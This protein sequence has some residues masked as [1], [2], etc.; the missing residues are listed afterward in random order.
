MRNPAKWSLPA[1]FGL[2]S[3]LIAGVGILGISYITYQD[4]AGL[5]RMHS[6]QRLGNDL[7]RLSMGLQQTVD[8]LRLDVQQIAD[9]DIIF[10]YNRA[11]SAGG[12]DSQTNMTDA[13]WKQRIQRNFITLLQQRP[14]YI[15]VRYISAQNKGKE[16]VR[17]ERSEGR[18]Q[19]TPENK[20]QQK[21]QYDY[22]RK[23]LKLAM[24][25]QYLSAVNLNREFGRIV[26][27]PQPVLRAAAPVYFHNQVFGVIVVNID[28][29]QI[30]TPFYHPPDNIQY[31]IADKKGDYLYHPDIT[32]R[33]TL[34]LGGRAGVG[35][36]FPQLA[37]PQY[38]DSNKGYSTIDLP[39]KNASM[40]I[41]FLRYDPQNSEHLLLIMAVASH[42]LL[43][44]QVR[45]FRQ[46]LITGVV[47][48]VI[49][50]SFIIS[51]MTY[52]LLQPIEALTHAA[53]LISHGQSNVTLPRTHRD[54]ALGKLA[55][56]FRTMLNH[57]QRSQDELRQLNTELEKKVETRTAELKDA[58]LAANRSAQVKSEFLAS[59]SHEIRTPMNGILGMLNLLLDTRL[60]E[61][62]LHYVNI[63]QGSAQ[64]LLTI[65]NDILDFSKIEAGK[66][67][68]EMM[69]F[70]L[71]NLLSDF[72]ETMALQAQK[73]NLELIL[74]IDPLNYP[75]IN[76]DPGRIRQILTNLTGN[77][78]KFTEQGE[79]I[80]HAR[81][82][83]LRDNLYLLHI[84]VQ[85]SGIGI[86]PEQQQ[87][88]FQS[89]SQGDA[90]TTRKYGGTGLGLAISK[91]LC[92]LMNGGIS[93][94][95]E[96]GKGSVFECTIQ[97]RATE[98]NAHN[99]YYMNLSR[100]YILIVD[101]NR[102]ARKALARILSAWG[103]TIIEA[104]NAPQ[105]LTQCQQRLQTGHRIFELAFINLR[106]AQING[107]ELSKQI[108]SCAE[109]QAMQI[110][111]M[112]HI[113]ETSTLPEYPSFVTPVHKP[114]TPVNLLPILTV[115]L[116]DNNSSISVLQAQQKEATVEADKTKSL[117]KKCPPDTRI[118]LVEDNRV[119]QFVALGILKKFRLRADIASDGVEALQQL[120]A[121]RD[122]IPYSLIL[123]DC[124]MP[125]MDGF[126][127]SRQIRGGAAGD[128]YRDIPIIAMT[129]NAMQGDREKCISAGMSDYISKPVN[130]DK[131]HEL[132]CQ[133]LLPENKSA[134]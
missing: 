6:A 11:L 46:R 3:L 105:A 111:L 122:N 39:Q 81:M 58:L 99:H 89:F 1:K 44:Q 51:M 90:S 98:D 75:Q 16:I 29:T 86:P 95:S 64:S 71:Y 10:H 20:L 78:I 14:E 130:P 13:L 35:E 45:N 28:F 36:D 131:L 32:R 68:L 133:W 76:S 96:A 2:L 120:Q 42:K 123:M 83:P 33:Y 66:L 97:V 47:I 84:R 30:I 127:A 70:N 52:H 69:D 4:V 79:V 107:I 100:K 77:A 24:N 119:N 37:L 132:L 121:S 72:V 104:D 108:Y 93:V 40:I 103:A 25:Q 128:E 125:E 7:Q 101:H 110:L 114:L 38:A 94:Q 106:L 63:A 53:D 91:Q 9:S 27:P 80:I 134:L 102:F 126:E 60:N 22:V 85:D 19:I 15:Q 87:K 48:V 56:S 31:Y 124:Q 5:L 12:Y 74:D 57:L 65:I 17:V 109:Y 41:H 67:E 92:E 73:K 23:T 34:A 112:T 118:L 43:N 26:F 129:A 55:Q 116:E 49:L 117:K 115:C 82:S 50:V 18:L 61:E 54:D 113:N 8:K 59:M 88:L 62:Q 21:G